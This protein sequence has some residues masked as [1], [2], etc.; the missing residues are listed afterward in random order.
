[1]I[2][3][4]KKD[5]KVLDFLQEMLYNN[6]MKMKSETKKENIMTIY[7][8]MDGVL[9]DFFKGL[10]DFYGLEHW[11][12]LPDKEKNITNLSK[13]DFFNTLD[14]F[15]TANDL[16]QFVKVVSQGDW[17]ICSSPL[18]GDRD[19]SA[20]WKRVWLTD[21][22]WLPDVDKL[23]FTGQKENYAVDKFTGQ[24]NLLIDDKP[25]NVKD[26][27]NKGG[28]AIRYQANEDSLE[29]LK[30]KVLELI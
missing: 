24:P 25:S 27:I 16:V 10:A 19:N 15:D 3:Q 30:K 13:T 12:Q 9:A 5:K 18:R 11:K 7:L 26:W 6:L 14:E 2:S 20:F 17:G 28:V 22:G 21:R 1:M 4:A 8:D 23:I 29:E